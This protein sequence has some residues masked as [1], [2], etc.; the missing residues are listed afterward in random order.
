MGSINNEHGFTITELLIAAAVGGVMAVVLFTATMF[1]YGGVMQND[2]RAR[3]IVESQNILRNVVDE[4]RVGSGIRTSNQ[5]TDANEPVGGWTTSNADLILI[6]ASPVLDSSGQFIVD[7][8]TGEPYQNELIYF[9]EG[10]T[11]YKRILANP[12]AVGNTL[13][14]SCPAAVS[15]PSCPPDRQLSENFT[16]MSFV[17]YDQDNT[18]TTDPALARSAAILIEMG[19][20]V[21]GQNIDID[22]QIR[23]TLRNKLT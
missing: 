8:L 10:T 3:L 22:N 11:L 7:P 1:M 23:I 20:R 18:E 21:Y 12:S 19:R 6:V 4:L 17:F 13:T 14:T 9:A 15:G 5:I 16:D 2:A